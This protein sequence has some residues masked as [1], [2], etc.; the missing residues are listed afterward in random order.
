MMN[1][2]G[3]NLGYGALASALSIVIWIL[4]L[5]W[6]RSVNFLGTGCRNAPIRGEEAKRSEEI[7]YHNE[8]IYRD[9]E[10]FYK[11]AAAILG[12][13]AYLVVQTQTPAITSHLNILIGYSSTLL[14]LTSAT[15]SVFLL[16]HQKSKV[17]RWTRR[18]SI[19]SVLAWQETWMIAIIWFLWA[20][21]AYGI[22][23]AILKSP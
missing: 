20:S 7:K 5:L 9:F 22:V 8:A 11:S 23:P 12:G 1:F 10:Y 18:Y 4:C 16:A 13:V 14:L 17:E 3:C 15:C 2:S 21:Y 6:I 19:W